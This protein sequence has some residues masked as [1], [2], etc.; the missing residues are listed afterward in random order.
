MAD[1]ES[2]ATTLSSPP[3]EALDKSEEPQ[4]P[5]N[6]AREGRILMILAPSR[7]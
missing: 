2:A 3:V 5:S 1:I 6:G 4:E 7:V